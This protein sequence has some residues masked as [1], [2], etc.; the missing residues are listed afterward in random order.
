MSKCSMVRIPLPRLMTIASGFSTQAS[1]ANVR[2]AR[3]GLGPSTCQSNP[4]FAKG[5]MAR[6]A[7]GSCGPFVSIARYSDTAH[8]EHRNVTVKSLN[9]GRGAERLPARP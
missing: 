8:S 6:F 5:W 2:L 4:A 7:S 1:G 9:D 3:T